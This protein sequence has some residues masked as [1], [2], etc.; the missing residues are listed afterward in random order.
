MPLRTTEAHTEI[1]GTLSVEVP[2]RGN[3]LEGGPLFPSSTFHF[4]PH[5][6]F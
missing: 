3:K 4:F 6:D 1:T 2:Q 5:F